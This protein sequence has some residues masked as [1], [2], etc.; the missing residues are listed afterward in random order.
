MREAGMIDWYAFW[1][2][3]PIRRA[4]YEPM[5]CFIRLIDAFWD[6]LRGDE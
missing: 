1:T 4:I 3:G 5:K 2:G 6:S